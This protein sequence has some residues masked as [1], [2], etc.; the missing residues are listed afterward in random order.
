MAD[1]LAGH[2][3]RKIAGKRG[4]VEADKVFRFPNFL[5]FWWEEG[6][7]PEF[8]SIT[9]F[10]KVATSLKT[11]FKHNVLQFCDGKMGAVNG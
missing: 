9:I 8:S 4:L 1:Q 10:L 7:L 3:Y 6:M 11:I 5:F 2:W